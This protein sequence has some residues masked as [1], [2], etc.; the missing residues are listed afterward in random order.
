LARRNYHPTLLGVFDQPNLTTAC[1][2]RQ[3]SAVVLQSLTMLND[4]FVRGRADEIAQRVVAEGHRD[5]AQ[6][7]EAAFL[8]TLSRAPKSQ[9]LGWSRTFLREMSAGAEDNASP[10]DAQRALEYLCHVLL[11]SSEFLY[12]P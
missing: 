1:S 4:P 11:N 2:R 9:E 5:A 7:I 8:L 3:A 6:Q 12:V 10:A